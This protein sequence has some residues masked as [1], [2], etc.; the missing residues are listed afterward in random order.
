MHEATIAQNIIQAIEQRIEGGEIDGRISKIFLQV[1]R[2]RSIVGEN[3]KFLFEV[4]SEGSP[5]EGSQLEIETVPVRAKCRKCQ[6]YFE[7]ED[8]GFLC[9]RCLSAEVEVIT[10]TELLISAVEV[11]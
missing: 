11:D 1:G 5:L 6:E 2:L 8:L 9:S 3:L 4:L 10:G 7:I